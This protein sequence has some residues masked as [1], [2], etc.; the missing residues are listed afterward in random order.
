MRRFTKI[1]APLATFVVAALSSVA[2]FASDA[3][4]PD[5][6]KGY[7]AIGAALAI[8]LAAFGGGLGQGRAAASALDGVARNPQASGK[9][10]VPMILG[11]ALIESLVIYGLI[12]A[13]ILVGKI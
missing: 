13:F 6:T 12:I 3:P 10:L 2:A 11:L 7:I 8:G 1:L 5:L 9:I 4:V